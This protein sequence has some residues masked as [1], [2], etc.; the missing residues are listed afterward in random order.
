MAAPAPSGLEGGE[1]S[2]ELPSALLSQCSALR[3]STPRRLSLSTEKGC[4]MV[5]RAGWVADK[6]ISASFGEAIGRGGTVM[7]PRCAL[8]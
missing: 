2:S 1:S 4:P 7:G 6:D 3:A 5:G 8:A